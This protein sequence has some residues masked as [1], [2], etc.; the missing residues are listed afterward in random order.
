MGWVYK[1]LL[2]GGYIIGEVDAAGQL[3][4]P[5]IAYVYPDFRTGLRGQFTD[6]ELVRGQEVRVVSGE[7]AEAGVMVP[8][9]SEVIRPEI[10]YC[11]DPASHLSISS[12]PL[13]RD[14]WEESMVEVRESG[15]E[16]A[17][18]GLFAR[19]DLPAKTIICLFAGVRLKTVTT[20]GRERARSDYRIKLTVDLDLDIPD[21]CTQLSSYQATLGHKA[22]HSFTPNG[23]FDRFEHPRFGL[24]R[25]ISSLEDIK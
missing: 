14:P 21:S 4:G 9:F 11:Y 20:G 18:Q 16:Q 8:V 6:E 15:L 1:G 12:D 19:T 10:S 23:T 3:T 22:N 24:I 13:L 25:A 5:S 7:V 17:G 2:G